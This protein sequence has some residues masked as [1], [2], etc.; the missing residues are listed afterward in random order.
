MYP[1]VLLLIDGDWTKSASGRSIPVVNP[2]TGEPIGTVAHA[3][4]AP[5]S[6][7]RWRR[8]RRASRPGARC[9]PSTAP[10]S[11]A[12]PPT[13]CASA[14]ITSRRCMTHGAGQAAGRSEGRDAGRR[15]RDR[16]VRRGSPPRL[17]PRHPGARR[18]RLPA[19]DEGAGGPGRRVH[20][21]ELPDQP[22]GAQAVGGAGRRLLDHRQGARGNAGLARR[23]DPRLRRCRRAGRRGQPGLRRAGGDFRIPHSASDHPQDVLHRLDPGRQ[24]A[25]R[26]GRRST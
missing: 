22:G 17:W 24:A 12:R 8:P 6:T 10:R 26:A 9:R 16:L 4:H 15:R 23:A 14:P 5:I 19:G 7:A 2:A 3:E 1:D 11:C 13:C 20:A 18:G 21:V 25:R